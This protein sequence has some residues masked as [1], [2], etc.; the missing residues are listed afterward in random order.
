MPLFGK[1]APEEMILEIVLL[2]IIAFLPSIIYMVVLR[3]IEKYDREP[4]GSLGNVFLWGA[5]MGVVVVIVVRGAFRVHFNDYYPELAS[6]HK[7]VGLILAV[8]ITPLIAEI[9]KPLGLLFVRHDIEEAEDG[10]IYGAVA[11]LGYAAT[12]NLL[13]GIFLVSIYG[14]EFFIYVIILRSISVVLLHAS[15]TALTGYG[16]SRATAAKHKVGSIFAFPLFLFAAIGLHSFF[17]Y[18]MVSGEGISDLV[19]V[20]SSF[21]LAI[22]ISIFFMG[23]IYFKIYRLDRLDEKE[24]ESDD[25]DDD[26]WPDERRRPVHR[27]ARQDDYY[28]RPG[29][30]GSPPA[31]GGRPVREDYYERGPPPRQRDDYYERGRAPPHHARAPHRGHAPAPAHQGHARGPHV[32][33]T[34][35]P[36]VYIEQPR[37]P[38]PR[39][40][41]AG[42]GK[43]KSFEVDEQKEPPKPKVFEAEWSAPSKP[44][45]S[46]KPKREPVPEDGEPEMVDWEEVVE[47]PPAEEKKKKGKGSKKPS[48]VDWSDDDIFKDD[49]E[50]D[51]I[52]WFDDD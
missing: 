36:E 16:V 14:M 18:L 51:E 32:R 30:H 44:R 3:Y 31:P 9:I 46:P 22:V 29:G 52:G 35:P 43:E 49:S 40:G 4:W 6:D 7:M 8:L 33:P 10:L 11:G 19:S 42:F 15:A 20:G 1:T 23:W 24:I 17:N 5:T 50:S 13:Y 21:S 47:E 45:A 39:R 12:E 26:S 28:G 2:I 25:Y 34:P 48:K 27:G 37:R 38:E 41:T